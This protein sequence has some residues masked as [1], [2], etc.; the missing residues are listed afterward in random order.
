MATVIKSSENPAEL[1]RYLDKHRVEAAQMK[2]MPPELGA[3][4]MGKLLA[5][6][7]NAPP[8]EPPKRVS[9][10]PEPIRTVKAKGSG[11]IDEDK[12][13]M[14]EWVKRRNQ[15]QFKKD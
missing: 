13:P 15:K 8:P 11:Q 4:A 12:L 2:V 10:A 1:L 6:L 5:R 7:E 3:A 14:D 9:Q